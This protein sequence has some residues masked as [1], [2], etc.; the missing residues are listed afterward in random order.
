[1]FHGEINNENIDNNDDDNNDDG[2]DNN[3]SN[4]HENE[5]ENENDND[6][7]DNDTNVMCCLLDCHKDSV[8]LDVTRNLQQRPLGVLLTLVSP[9]DCFRGKWEGKIACP[10]IQHSVHQCARF[11]NAARHSHA[12]AVK[13]IVGHL[14]GLLKAEEGLQFIVSGDFN[15]D[16]CVNTNFAGLW[17]H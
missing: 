10:E 15:L 4:E 6:N 9:V 8:L 2:G 13:R 1:M 14:K 3:D 11:T 5:N 16:S 7:D 17:T 12:E